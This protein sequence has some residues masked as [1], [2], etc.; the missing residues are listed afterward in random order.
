MLPVMFWGVYPRKK[1]ADSG[2]TPPAAMIVVVGIGAIA[3]VRDDGACVVPLY[4][5]GP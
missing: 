2:D 3:Q 4:L 1:M 5:M